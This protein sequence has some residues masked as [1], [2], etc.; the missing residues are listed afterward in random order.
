M[1]ERGATKEPRKRA[2]GSARIGRLEAGEAGQPARFVE[3]AEP[4][5]REFDPAPVAEG[6]GMWWKSGS[7]R[8]FV[9][10]SE[11]S[12]W[13]VW[14]EDAVVDKLRQD[15]CISIK[16]RE[17]ERLS[18]S[19]RVFLWVRENR[20]LDE[21]FPALPGYRSGVHRLDSGERVLVKSQPSLVEPVAGEWPTIRALIEGLLGTEQ[22]TYFYSWCQRAHISLRDGDPGNWA[23]G[24]ALI[25]AGPRGAGKSL[26]QTKIITPILGGREADPQKFLF[27]TDDFNGD[28]FSAEH[29]NLGEVPSSQ[30]TVDRMALAET[31]KQIVATPLARMRLMRTEPWS[32]HPYWRLTISL[33]DDPDKLRSL[34]PITADLGDKVIIFHTRKAAMPMP[35]TT[36][37]ERRAFS[38]AIADEMPAF[39]HWLLTEW[40]I[41]AEL[42]KYPDGTDATRF[43]FREYHSTLIKDGL[44]D[45]T[46]AGE[47]MMLIDNAEFEHEGRKGLKLWDLDSA[48]HHNAGQPGKCWHGSALLLERILCGQEEPRCSIGEQFREFF[49]KNALPRLLQ[50]LNEHP[51][52]GDGKRIAKGDTRRWKGWIIGR[53]V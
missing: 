32:V 45:E 15:H 48:P 35:T 42:L 36:L 30:K 50:R 34:P 8:S 10:G 52:L 25:F 20:C 4:P 16:A 39:L 19:K 21:I 43:G 5:A 37:D 51:E 7:G 1:S 26:I 27:G 41:P 40:T 14:P 13:S 11:K 2:K 33:N 46:P 22:A 47:L 29:L 23:P 12:G 17:D 6:M 44:F 3:A 38:Q 9:L 18:E 31:I 28:C 24:H 53:P 49:K